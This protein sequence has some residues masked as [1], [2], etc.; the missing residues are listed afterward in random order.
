MKVLKWLAILFSALI[1][2]AIGAGIFFYTKLSPSYSGNVSLALNDSVNVYFDAYGIPHIEAGS[3]T[4]A[5]KALG[6]IHAQERLFQMELLR[7]VGSGTLAEALGPDV[8]NVDRFFRTM[9]IPKHA[10]LSASQF[11]SSNHPSLPAVEA[12]ISG[13]NAYIATDNPP[14][15][16]RLAGIPLRQFSLEDCFYIVGYM[17]YSFDQSLKTDPIYDHLLRSKGESYYNDLSTNRDSTQTFIPFEGGLDSALV[18]LANQAFEELPL[19]IFNASNAWVIAPYKTA[20]H[21]VLFANDTHIEHAQPSTWFEAHLEAPGLRLYGNFL[22]G[23]P[24]PLIGH[25]DRHAWG[26]TMYLNDDLDLYRET[27]SDQDVFYQNKLVPLKTEQHTIAVKDDDDVTFEVRITPHGPIINDAVDAIQAKDPISASWTYTKFPS[28]AVETAYGFYKAKDINA[29]YSAASLLAAPGL[30]VMYGDQGGNIGWWATGKLIRRPAHVSGRTILDGK[31]GRDDIQGYYDFAYNP[32][33][34]NPEKGYVY[35]ANNASYTADSTVIPGYYYHGVR[36]HIIDSMLQQSNTWTIEMVKELQANNVSSLYPRLAKVLL[37]DLAEPA[38][39]YDDSLRTALAEWNGAHAAGEVGPAIYY[40][41]TNNLAKTALGDD[42]KNT[43]YQLLRKSM[44]SMNTLTELIQNNASV[45]WDIPATAS[46]ENR[47]KIA[48]HAW[49]LTI[50]QL[51]E[52][53]PKGIK[54]MS[55]EKVCLLTFRHP[56]SAMSPLDKLF[57]VGPYSTQG[58][59]EVVNKQNFTLQLNG[60][61]DVKGGPAM[62]I[63]IDFKDVEHAESVLPS[64]Q[65]GNPFSP[66]YSDQAALYVNEETRLMQMNLLEIKRNAIS[67]VTF[68][69]DYKNE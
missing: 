20:N 7:R 16:F 55:W 18:A 42:L 14:I 4:D 40:H 49:Q 15:E 3:E 38:S 65:S 64:G 53:Y 41:F 12:Y 29:F 23:F 19:P 25:T 13:I 60:T 32:H 57:N 59:E 52:R 30:N 63:A 45:W 11:K 48:E 69:P 9:G 51:K 67:K 1:I 47:S 31:T 36:A 17:S 61:F 21:Q 50:R 24:F 34:I 43:D 62:R 35:S 44:S 22:A 37:R 58:G 10:R 46:V 39:A 66:H 6:Y 5:F 26:L 33:S 28:R 2:V 56:F 54:S 68:V 27:L 8:V